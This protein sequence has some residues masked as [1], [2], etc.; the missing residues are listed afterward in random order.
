LK[1]YAIFLEILQCR[2]EIATYAQL[3]DS[4]FALKMKQQ[5]Y[6]LLLISGNCG[7]FTVVDWLDL[8]AQAKILAAVG[9]FQCNNR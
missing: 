5:I 6:N 3:C 1:N 8:C 4:Y 2:P 9:L 7:K